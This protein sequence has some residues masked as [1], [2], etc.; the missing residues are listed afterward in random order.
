MSGPFDALAPPSRELYSHKKAQKP[1]KERRQKP[2]HQ[3]RN[4]KGITNC[5]LPTANFS[6]NPL[7]A[8]KTLGELCLNTI[9]LRDST[10]EGTEES[11]SETLRGRSTFQVTRATVV[12]RFQ[13]V[14]GVG[15]PS[16]NMKAYENYPTGSGVAA[17]K[18]GP[19]GAVRLR[20]R[21]M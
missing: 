1:Q 9:I 8:H 3:S 10:A 15:D 16:Y 17:P 12:R 4:Q 19:G 11:D 5:Q 2:P 20:R 6:P 14:A 21:Q 13:V 18:L 7:I